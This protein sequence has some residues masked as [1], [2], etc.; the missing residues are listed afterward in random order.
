MSR[1]LWAVLNLVRLIR[2][3]IN[4]PPLKTCSVKA[5][6][7]MNSSIRLMKQ[8]KGRPIAAISVLL[9]TF[10]FDASLAGANEHAGRCERHILH[11]AK[12]YQVPV[13]ILY[14][15]GLTETGNKGSLHPFAMNVEGRSMFTASKSEALRR[16]AKAKASGAKLIDVGCM[17]INHYWHKSA[18]A[19]VEE[20]FEPEKNVAYAAKFLSKLRKREGNWTLA[21][22]R[23]HAGPDNNPAQK[24]YVCRVLANIVAAGFGKWSQTSRTFCGKP[25]RRSQKK[26]R[27]KSVG[28]TL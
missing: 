1:K 20:M 10:I 9:A 8:I 3:P 24:K 5:I 22:A 13:G 4:M 23:Y 12:K 2:V 11:N 6:A 21:V 27:P 18:F 7:A 14:A 16:F 15:V 19:S 25:Q 28:R 26:V 17:Q